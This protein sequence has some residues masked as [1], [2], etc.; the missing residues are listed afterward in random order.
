LGAGGERSVVD[1]D[2]SGA[3]AKLV[4]AE[5][6]HAVDRHRILVAATAEL[7]ARRPPLGHRLA[8]ASA[9]LR[10]SCARLK[11]NV[12]L[13]QESHH[14]AFTPDGR[15]AWITD[16][17]AG[18]VFVVDA[19]S[20]D[21]IASL[22]VSGPHHVA[23]TPD[24]RLAAVAGHESG[25]VVVYNVTRRARIRVIELGAGPYGVWA[26]PTEAGL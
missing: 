5:H 7:G 24:G 26:V 1:V 22:P 6:R 12:E 20:L 2:R 14:L 23:I 15:Q 4:D 16:H 9:R 13:G 18:R 11:G 10:P 25:T 3:A 19:R 21:V 8:R 17:A